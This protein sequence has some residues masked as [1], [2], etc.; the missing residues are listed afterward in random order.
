VSFT[1]DPIELSRA[2]IR[3]PSLTPADA[4]ALD[5]LEL[6]LR[7]LGFN[8]ERLLF[9]EAGTAPVDNLYARWG[10]EAP[11]FCFTGHTDVVPPGDRADWS[12]DPFSGE[13]RDGRLF[14]RGASDMKAAIACFVVAAARYIEACREEGRGSI[15][16]LITGDEEGPSINGT[17]KVLRALIERGETLDACLVG[18]PTNPTTLGEMI[19]IGRR[20]SLNAVLTVAG[21]QGHS[22][23][24]HL[25]DNPIP[26]L[27]RMLAAIDATP[28]DAG[29]AHF[30][31]STVAITSVDVDNPATNVIPARAKAMLNVRF[32]DLHTGESIAAWL[33]ARCAEV[34]GAFNMHIECS[35]EA[36]VCP[37]GDLSRIVTAAVRRVTGR[38]PELSTSGGTSDARFIKDVCTVCEFGMPGGTAHK[39]DESVALADIEALTCIYHEILKDFF[40]K[41]PAC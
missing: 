10:S 21:E 40:A 18:E 31:P 34:G 6:A 14:G 19:K 4:G 8:C 9:E 25:A 7:P 5:V 22:A 28:L 16:L 41:A 17:K 27:V 23:Y 2:L 30:E 38:E 33:N 32:N 29:T 12:I 11:N 3:C 26:R 1:I 15:S 36:F 13:I 20:G 35:G 39:V 37:P 24:P